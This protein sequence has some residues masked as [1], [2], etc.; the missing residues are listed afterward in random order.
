MWGSSATGGIDRGIYMLVRREMGSNAATWDL[1]TLRIWKSNMDNFF[2][3]MMGF[4]L[5]IFSCYHGGILLCVHVFV[6]F[7]GA[8]KLGLYQN[9]IR[10]FCGIEWNL[11][12]LQ[13]L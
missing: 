3:K 13:L 7:L 2:K 10:L 4:S 1:E 12:W 11:P 6:F 9:Y 8:Q 5:R